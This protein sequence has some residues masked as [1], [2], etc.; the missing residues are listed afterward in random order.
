MW[1]TA[2]S[3]PHTTSLKLLCSSK[4]DD[5]LPQCLDAIVY[6]VNKL[7]MVRPTQGNTSCQHIAEQRKP[8]EVIYWVHFFSSKQMTKLVKKM[9]V[10]ITKDG[11]QLQN[12]ITA[13]TTPSPKRCFSKKEKQPRLTNRFQILGCTWPH[14][15]QP[16]ASLLQEKRTFVTS[17]FGAK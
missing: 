11:I 4:G 8:F 16:Y 1:P 5:I 9:Y 10:L 15:P 12:K 13:I 2:S 7:C 6:S 17:D 3:L 14:I